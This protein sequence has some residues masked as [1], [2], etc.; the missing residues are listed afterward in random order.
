M[1]KERYIQKWFVKIGVEEL[2]WPAQ[3]PDLKPIDHLWDELE[4]R[5]RAR[6]N[7]PT[8]VPD[9]TNALVAEWEKVPAVMFKHLVESLPR[10]VEAIIA[11]KG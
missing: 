2:D 5:L 11:A 1:H 7:H 8:S 6:S 3:S 4:R 10:R 9:L